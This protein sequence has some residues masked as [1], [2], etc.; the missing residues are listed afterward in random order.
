M[1][2]YP[3]Q[4]PVSQTHH[5]PQLHFPDRQ[6]NISAGFWFRWHEVEHPG[7]YWAQ[8][9][10]FRD[11]YVLKKPKPKKSSWCFL[12]SEKIFKRATISPSQVYSEIKTMGKMIFTA[13]FLQHN[14][15]VRHA[16]EEVPFTKFKIIQKTY[17]G[18]QP[19]PVLTRPVNLFLHF[20]ELERLRI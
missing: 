18:T 7:Q 14:A 1:I 4:D 17:T 9:R 5:P 20:T 8:S 15:T 13:L 16:E 10:H 19:H 12:G 6:K 2:P 11:G 3:C